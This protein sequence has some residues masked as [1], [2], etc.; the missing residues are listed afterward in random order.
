MNQ[1]MDED[2]LTQ[3]IIDSFAGV[4]TATAYGY[5]FFFYGRERKLPFATIASG[6]NEHD[7]VSNLD[8]A[9]VFRLNI[10]VRSETYRALFGPSRPGSAR[11][12]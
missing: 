10:G 5:T 12:E 11:Q 1:G 7:R 3:H 6:D 8:R 2:A 9:G 4:E